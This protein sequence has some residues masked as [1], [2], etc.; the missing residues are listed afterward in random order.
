LYRK[1]LIP[2]QDLFKP[3]GCLD[4]NGYIKVSINYRACYAHQIIWLLHTG[5]WPEILLDHRDKDKANNRPGNLREATHR[6]NS[7]NAKKYVNNTTGVRGVSFSK[8]SGY[9]VTIA[10]KFLGYYPFLKDAKE[11]ADA[12]YRYIDNEPR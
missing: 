7:L 8:Q 2:G 3:L 1:Y 5:E 9:K 6:I 12:H 4:T 10:G 11:V